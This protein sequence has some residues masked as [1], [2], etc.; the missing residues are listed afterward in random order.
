MCFTSCVSHCLILFISPNTYRHPPTDKR[1]KNCFVI[2]DTGSCVQVH[3]VRVRQASASKVYQTLCKAAPALL[4]NT[5]CPFNTW[6]MK[7][8]PPAA[9]QN[10]SPG[11]T[12]GFFPAV[13]V[14]C[15]WRYVG[16][17]TLGF[18]RLGLLFTFVSWTT[19]NDRTT[20]APRK[21]NTGMV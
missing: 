12:V 19:K 9:G 16:R 8:A 14:V 3:H 10:C 17:L 6:S 2:K 5:S 13:V 1:H 20:I 4:L 21:A 7:P 11:Q 18:L 15:C